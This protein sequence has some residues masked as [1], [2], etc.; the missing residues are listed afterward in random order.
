MPEKLPL[1]NDNRCEMEIEGR[2]RPQ[3]RIMVKK[4]LL[5]LVSERD[6]LLPRTVL[7]AGS[8]ICYDTS[9]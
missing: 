5:L 8:R 9:D 2:L 1:D 4:R 3:G 7:L 6:P